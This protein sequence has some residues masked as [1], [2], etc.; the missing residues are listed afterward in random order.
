MGNDFCP[1]VPDWTRIFGQLSALRGKGRIITLVLPVVSDREI[2]PVQKFLDELIRRELWPE[3]IVFNDWGVYN[4]IREMGSRLVL[5]RLLTHQ[6]R[7]IRFMDS[8]KPRN[9]LLFGESFRDFLVELGVRAVELDYIP[10]N[11]VAGLAYHLHTPFRF[12]TTS[13]LCPVANLYQRRRR[14]TTV[15]ARYCERKFFE[16]REGKH[17]MVQFGNSLFVELP[18]PTRKI[19][20]FINRVV[21][22][23]GM[24]Y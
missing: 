4:L 23:T 5:G 10:E 20:A 3:E 13:R 22:R 8:R 12:V 16:G 17:K 21:E 15:C 19:P 6:T 1:L 9:Q 11:P 2:L 18:E 24:V 14:I 7:D